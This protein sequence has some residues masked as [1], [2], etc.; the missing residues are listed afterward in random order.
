[1]GDKIVEIATEI[2]CTPSQIAINWVRQQKQA[3]IIPI[4]GVRTLEQ[5]QD[6]LGVLDFELTDEQIEEI[7]KSRDSSLNL[8]D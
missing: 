1:M 2:G 3:Q 7:D 5:L 4:L 8:K 6:N